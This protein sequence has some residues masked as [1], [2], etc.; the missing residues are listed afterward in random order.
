MTFREQWRKFQLLL[1]IACGTCP[2]V[3][4]LLD[5]MS[6]G[7]L[8]W[9]WLFSVAY[10]VLALLGIQVKG[11]VRMSVGI[12]LSAAYLAAA[13]LL[14]PSEYRLGAVAAAAVCIA[15]LIWSL[16]MGG[17]SKK[18]EIPVFWV[19]AG[20]ICHFIGQVSLHVD[21]ISD[22]PELSRYSGVFLAALFGFCLLTML[23]MNRKS[24]TEASGKRQ[25]VPNS[26]RRRN[27]VM[28]VVLF[29]AALLTALLPSVFA[30]LGDVMVKAIRALVN[31][32]SK[33]IP[34]GTKGQG[35]T[36]DGSM[37]P[38]QI[39]DIGGDGGMQ[40]NPL[41]EKIAVFVGALLSIAFICFILYRIFV[42]LKDKFGELAV[43][44]GK[45]ASNVSEDYVDEITDTRE[46]GTAEK[47]Q[48]RRRTTRLSAREERSLPPEERIR[49]RYRRIL[50]RHPEWAPGATARETLSSDMA[51]VYEKARYS[52]ETITEEEAAAFTGG[53]SV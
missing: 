24:L 11:A 4:L 31:F 48:R 8:P 15:L 28:T 7:L 53:T 41:A 51:R 20:M 30:G 38:P 32:L 40:L 14:S 16:K 19:A 10:V 50:S 49:Y 13:F 35:T 23:S 27:T 1:I 17:W 33:L 25:S 52:G 37:M 29:A 2:V 45:F 21:R 9:G 12:A 42:L 26:M 3:M 44:L 34:E 6:P 22:D 39:G 36:S 46:D 43:S 18:E 5:N 47:L